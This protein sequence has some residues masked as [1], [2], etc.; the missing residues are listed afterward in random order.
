MV[1]DEVASFDNTVAGKAGVMHRL[2][3]G[4]A[5]VKLSKAPAAARGVSARVLDHELDTVL[6][7]PRHERLS[8]AKGFAAFLQRVVAPGE[9]GHNCAVRVRKL[10]V[11]RGLE[12][13]VVAQNGA[14]VVEAAFLVS[15]GDQPPLAVPGGNFYAEE[16]RCIVFGMPCCER[17]G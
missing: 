1:E 13:Y 2:A 8:A 7:W 4:F 9:A 15:H 10:L 5:V 6:G 12:R 14:Q 3:G 16:G 11:P 17:Q